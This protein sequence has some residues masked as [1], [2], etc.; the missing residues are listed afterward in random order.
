[1][2]TML[3]AIFALFAIGCSPCDESQEGYVGCVDGVSVVVDNKTNVEPGDEA[4]FVDSDG[5]VEEVSA[6]LDE[7]MALWGVDRG[8]WSGY[9]VTVRA[10]NGRCVDVWANG[11]T[12]RSN[13]TI[14]VVPIMH[15]RTHNLVHELGHAVI[16]DPDHNDPRFK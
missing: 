11:C 4:R 1:M 5:L 7:A 13:Q 10:I 2:R 6:R 14:W 8:F 3:V 16:G 9:T 12:S 15:D